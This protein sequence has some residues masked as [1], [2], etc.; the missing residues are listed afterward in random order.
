MATTPEGL[1]TSTAINDR[2]HGALVKVTAGFC[3][4]LSLLALV[5]RL[6]I[7]WPWRSLFG[8][9]DIVAVVATVSLSWTCK[10]S[11]SL[12]ILVQA[13]AITQMV[14]VVYGVSEGFGKNVEDL[15]SATIE[16]VGKVQDCP[17]PVQSSCN[18]ADCS[19]RS[20]MP[21]TSFSW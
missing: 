11:P 4:A 18:I 14:V 5:A 12:L 8:K 20:S 21:A 7:R 16:S 6:Q 10:V 9:D 1:S 19:S 13:F 15:S 17:H 3:T 2:D